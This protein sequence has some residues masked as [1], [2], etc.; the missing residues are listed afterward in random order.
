VEKLHTFNMNDVGSNPSA[1]TMK[2]IINFVRRLLPTKQ[3]KCGVCGKRN[4]KVRLYRPYGNFYRKKDN[5]CNEHIDE[6]ERGWMVPLCMSEDGLPWGYTSVPEEDC[7]K[8][9]AKPD[10]N[11]N[12]PIW[13]IR[14]GW[15]GKD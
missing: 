9:Y 1:P 14:G 13:H 5:R 6:S 2:T 15:D 4:N 3:P 8:F 7:E 11:K 12:Y 10:A